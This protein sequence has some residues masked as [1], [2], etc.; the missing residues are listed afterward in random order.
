M[1]HHGPSGARGLLISFDGV[2]SSGKETQAKALVDR[3]R[4]QG[5]TVRQ[6]V[7]PDY[8]TPSG[9]DLKLRLQGKKG[10]WASTSWEEKM[11]YFAN[12]RAEHKEEVL[13]ALDT[14][15]M[16]VYDRYVPS[17]LA[18]V[19]IE[20]LL[21]QEVSIWREDVYNAVRDYEYG[22]HKMPR[23]DVSIFLDVPP[24]VSA[25]LLEKR[26]EKLQ[27]EDEYTDHLHVQERL[28]NE[29][30]ELLKAMPER[31][32]RI[33]CLDGNELLPI[34]ATQELVWEGLTARFPELAQS[35]AKA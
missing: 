2:D 27:D 15:E 10:D 25:E 9:R 18:F 1:H 13:D 5:Y 28:Y 24:K 34:T 29:Y 21:A 11:R 32:L 31:F 3:L 16:V 19:A 7:T 14:G 30:L 23:E 17:S 33:P 35:N 20:A 22:Q 26:K 4:Y 12:N 6:F 8:S